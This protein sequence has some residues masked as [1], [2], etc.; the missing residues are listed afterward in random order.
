M[1]ESQIVEIIKN[2]TSGM[3]WG[4]PAF[5][6]DSLESPPMAGFPVWSLCPLPFP[7]RVV[8]L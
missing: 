7:D 4:S 3:S 2:I 5:P 1:F 6:P 8:P